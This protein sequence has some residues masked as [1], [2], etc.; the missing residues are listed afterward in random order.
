MTSKADVA[1][2]LLALELQYERDGK[3]E[4]AAFDRWSALA[5]QIF[6]PSTAPPHATRK[7]FR[8]PASE[9]CNIRIANAAANCRVVNLSLVGATL[10]GTPLGRASSGDPVVLVDVTV[11]GQVIELEL[12]A[13]LIRTDQKEGEP[14]AGVEFGRGND[15][16]AL[17]RFFR[18]VYY[19]IYKRYLDRLA[20]GSKAT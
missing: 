13:R 9:A 5:A 1:R 6:A 12:T 8:L 4:G 16:A 11:D 10:A 15:G 20:T 2:E 18:L 3:L 14:V 7:S 17:E 19:P